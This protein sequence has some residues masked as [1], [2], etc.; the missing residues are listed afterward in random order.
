[1]YLICDARDSNIYQMGKKVATYSS[2]PVINKGH[3][4][5]LS[6]EVVTRTGLSRPL[7][8][9]ALR[10]NDTSTDKRLE[11]VKVAL[12]IISERREARK[13]VAA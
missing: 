1:M 13:G 7:V 12:A 10:E 2:H 4:H 8:D 5:G 9:K 6:K 3:F 11:A